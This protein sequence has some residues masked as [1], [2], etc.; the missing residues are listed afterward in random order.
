M[1]NATDLGAVTVLSL[2][3]TA[4]PM[5]SLWAAQSAVVVFLRHYG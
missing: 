3:G 5:S 4:V 2:D 1:N